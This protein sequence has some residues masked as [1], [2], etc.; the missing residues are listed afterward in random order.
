MKVFLSQA[1]G[2]KQTTGGTLSD[3]CAPP[4]HRTVAKT[5]HWKY[6]S[7]VVITSSEYIS[8]SCSIVPKARHETISDV[9]GSRSKIFTNIR[10][11]SPPKA[12]PPSLASSGWQSPDNPSQSFGSRLMLA[13]PFGRGLRSETGSRD[14]QG[15]CTTNDSGPRTFLR[16]RPIVTDADN[17]LRLFV[18]PVRILTACLHNAD[19]V[20]RLYGPMHFFHEIGIHAF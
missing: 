12:S 20:T 19:W 11:P 4:V 10:V 15:L 18:G 16:F 9:A 6:G 3:R 8:K 5:G 1:S 13:G 17:P 7:Q 14:M 2:Q